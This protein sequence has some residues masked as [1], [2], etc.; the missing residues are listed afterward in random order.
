MKWHRNCQGRNTASCQLRGCLNV[1]TIQQI[2][3]TILCFSNGEMA[4]KGHSNTKQNI[5]WHHQHHFSSSKSSFLLRE[6]KIIALHVTKRC[7]NHFSILLH[8]RHS[9]YFFAF[10]FTHRH[11]PLHHPDIKCFTTFT[12]RKTYA[13]I[14]IAKLEF[15]SIV[16]GVCVCVCVLVDVTARTFSKRQD[17][18]AACWCKTDVGFCFF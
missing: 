8:F 9:R 16:F 10:W 6:E 7:C 18:A 5:I 15:Y 17:L 13:T 3:A 12:S 2:N 1:N 14:S 4:T 11:C